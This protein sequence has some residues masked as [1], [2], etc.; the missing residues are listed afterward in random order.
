M[1]HGLRTLPLEVFPS[2]RRLRLRG[3]SEIDD[4]AAA[5]GPPRDRLLEDDLGIAEV[6][7]GDDPED[8]R[9]HHTQRRPVDHLPGERA[10]PVA[11]HDL[12]VGLL[13]DVEVS[14]DPP[15][16]IDEHLWRPARARALD[17]QRRPIALVD[18]VADALADDADEPCGL[19][20]PDH[21]LQGPRELA[22]QRAEKDVVLQGEARS[23]GAAFGADDFS[24]RIRRGDRRVLDGGI[25][26][27]DLTYFTCFAE[28]IVIPVGTVDSVETVR[29]DVDGSE[30][31]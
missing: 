15:L 5:G 19:I 24:I 30:P 12:L 11:E 6:L 21:L 10:S 23:S 17:A 8:V 27:S 13:D 3:R 28:G 25:A 4:D 9:G 22:D 16:Q 20:Q 31:E 1:R 18:L 14:L 2:L 29:M 7:G 26:V